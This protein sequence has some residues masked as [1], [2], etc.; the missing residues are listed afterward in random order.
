LTTNL[1]THFCIVPS[2]FGD[3]LTSVISSFRSYCLNFN[4]LRFFKKDIE[5][6][7]NLDDH[8]RY[9]CFF[10]QL[11]GSWRV[12]GVYCHRDRKNYHPVFVSKQKFPFYSVNFGH[13][14]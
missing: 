4:R 6:I 2:P 11:T 3:S 8:Y 1:Q 9:I 14:Y 10:G 13:K 12:H 5:S 7:R